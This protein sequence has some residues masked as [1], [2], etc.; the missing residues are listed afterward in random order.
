MENNTRELE[1]QLVQHMEAITNIAMQEL[2]LAEM[3]E[4][5]RSQKKTLVKAIKKL[6]EKLNSARQ[7]VPQQEVVGSK[8]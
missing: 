4:D 8:V 1:Q 3:I 2:D 6:S 7:E 5:L